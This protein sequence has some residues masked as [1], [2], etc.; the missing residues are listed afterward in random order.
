MR[1]KA[2]KDITYVGKQCPKT[3]EFV[4]SL[5][6]ARIDDVRYLVIKSGGYIAEH[7]DVP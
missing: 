1:S 7:V 6:Y 2:K 3:M 4:N 5:P